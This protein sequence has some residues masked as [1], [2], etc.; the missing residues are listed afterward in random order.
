MHALRRHDMRADRIDQETHQPRRLP[1]PVRQGRAVE[2]DPVAGVDLSL[3]IQREMIA[4]FRHQ[5]MRQKPGTGHATM[6]WQ[7]RCGRLR[8]PFAAPARQLRPHMP[9]DAERARHVVQHLG[10]VLAERA[11]RTAAFRAG[12][13]GGMLHHVARQGLG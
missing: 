3:A 4:V 13:G 7:A 6:D 12:A 11:E 8:D 10:D 5:H 1:D 9:D 2:V